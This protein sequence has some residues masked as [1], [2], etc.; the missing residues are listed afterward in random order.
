MLPSTCINDLCARMILLMQVQIKT[1]IPMHLVRNARICTI[2]FPMK[3]D[4]LRVIHQVLV[5]C[6]TR[7]DCHYS[8]RRFS[9]QPV[10]L[11]SLDFWKARWKNVVPTTRDFTEGSQTHKTPTQLYKLLSWGVCVGIERG[12]LYSPNQNGKHLQNILFSMT[13]SM[14]GDKNVGMSFK[15]LGG[16]I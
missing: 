16:V 3:H 1:E 6:D 12:K 13:L 8:V 5:S 15:A 2:V 4:L 9:C 11:H 7:Q 10:I 14:G